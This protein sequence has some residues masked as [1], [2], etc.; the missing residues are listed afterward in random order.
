[1]PLFGDNIA[2]LRRVAGQRLSFPSMKFAKELS[3]LK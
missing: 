2:E 1:M 3:V